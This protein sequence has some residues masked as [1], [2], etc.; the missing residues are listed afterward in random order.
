MTG[1]AE[2]RE[3]ITRENGA[4]VIH[5]LVVFAA[6]LKLLAPAEGAS[7]VKFDSK[8]SLADN[9]HQVVNVSTPV[10]SGRSSNKISVLQRANS[11]GL[12]DN[13]PDSYPPF[14][15]TQLQ[16]IDE[17]ELLNDAADCD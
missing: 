8:H 11:L 16:I 5:V 9:L 4:S 3:L 13:T 12:V 15:C 14:T 6:T 7:D 10:E 1:P 17:A 2:R